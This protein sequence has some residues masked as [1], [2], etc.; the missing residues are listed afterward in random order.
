MLMLCYDNKRRQYVLIKLTILFLIVIIIHQRFVF[1]SF[2]LVNT[3]H[4][5]VAYVR[6]GL[7]DDKDFFWLE[8]LL[9]L[10][11]MTRIFW[12]CIFLDKDCYIYY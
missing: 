7:T 12:C 2:V 6:E 11:R 10:Y 1:V 4:Q 8:L 5:H 3:I 9:T